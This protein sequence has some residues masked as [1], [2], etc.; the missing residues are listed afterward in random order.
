MNI[1]AKFFGAIL[2]LVAQ[3]SGAIWWAS[4][5]SS[6]VERLSG[7]QGDAIPALEAE[8]QKCGIAIH[9]NEAAI[10]ELQEHDQAISGLDV[11][12]F[13]IDELRKEISSLRKVDQDIM[14]QHE[15]I[16]DWM[17]SSNQQKKGNYPSYD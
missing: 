13:K 16:F 17:A 7:I 8:A 5:L 15:K 9:N 6:E 3:T 10:K 12:E 4:S 2:F 11:L 14:T 1:D